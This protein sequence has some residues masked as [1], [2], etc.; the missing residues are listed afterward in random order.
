MSDA[1]NTLPDGTDVRVPRTKLKT[2]GHRGYEE[3]REGQDVPVRPTFDYEP[4]HGDEGRCDDDDKPCRPAVPRQ[5]TRTRKSLMR[6]L[7]RPLLFA[8]AAVAAGGGTYLYL[9]RDSAPDSQQKQSGPAIPGQSSSPE[10]EPVKK[11]FR[12]TVQI[13]DKGHPTITSNDPSVKIEI[14]PE[15][16]IDKGQGDWEIEPE[17]VTIT[18]NGETYES[19]G[20][21]GGN[22]EPRPCEVEAVAS[23]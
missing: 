2:R 7:G 19:L 10:K 13:D 18:V 9:T 20:P 4:G 23:Q 22:G 8:G 12:F 14:N 21:I 15:F 11:I 6:T 1:E 17:G 5:R 3:Y 16:L